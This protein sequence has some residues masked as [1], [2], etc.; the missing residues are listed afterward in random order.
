MK[1]RSKCSGQ[2]MVTSVLKGLTEADLFNM[3][4]NFPKVRKRVEVERS[5]A[6]DEG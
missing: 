5:Q 1:L 4:G 3:R 6:S 2:V